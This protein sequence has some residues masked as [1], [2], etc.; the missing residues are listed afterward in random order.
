MSKRNLIL[1][2]VA[3]WALLLLAPLSFMYHG[4][5]VSLAHF[6]MVS[7]SPL[8]TMLVFYLNYLWLTPRFF[9][10]GEK[11]YY[12]LINAV[13]CIGLGVALHFW[14][15]YVHGLF[16]DRPRQYEPTVLQVALFILRDIFNL[17]LAAA[18]ATTVQLSLRWYN[19]EEAR[20]EAET[21]RTEAE[22]RNLRNQISPHFL[23]NTLNNI[24]ALTAFD[25]ERAQ[26]AIEQLSRMLRHM[27]YDNQQELVDWDKEV[28][29]LESYVSLMKIRLSQAVDVSFT[30]R[31]TAD[32]AVKVSPLLF[33]SLIENAFKHGISPTEP[34]FIHMLLETD[35][36]H[37]TC[38]IE[39][40]NHPK[41]EQDRSGHGI[42]LRQVQHRLDL[43]Y[44][45]RYTWER[46][47]NADGTI[48]RSC[49]TINPLKP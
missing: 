32:A 7:V 19:S 23:L 1:L 49:I 6:L 33:I 5:G 45:H 46:G 21:A 39:N 29:F 13:L 27:L 38:D 12:F 31:N 30:A 48:Y 4:D 17:V 43:S 24:Y 9:V 25:S 42:G 14:L 3:V 15:S 28:Q 41:N 18:I 40:S 22:L 37:I 26:Q 20:L 11:E 34:S 36:Q 2:Q 8:L 44:P 16:E 10:K 35:G 47:L